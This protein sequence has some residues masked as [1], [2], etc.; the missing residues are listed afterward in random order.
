MEK[1]KY[2]IPVIEFISFTLPES[3]CGS[4]PSTG[5]VWKTEDNYDLF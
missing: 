2:L 4:K 5:E 3:I 1:K